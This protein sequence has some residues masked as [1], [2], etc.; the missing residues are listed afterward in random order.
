MKTNQIKKAIVSVSNKNYLDILAE[1]F[2]NFKIEVLSTGGTSEFLRNYS[3]KI[4]VIDI[5]DF[6]KFNE[7]LDGRVKSLHPFIHSG[8]LAKKDCT[9][10]L[11]QNT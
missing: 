6:T 1:Y 4:K 10:R 5:S 3:S 7:I 11:E 2:I 8:I 9:K